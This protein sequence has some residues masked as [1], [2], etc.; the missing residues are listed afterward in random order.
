[1]E[2]RI[3]N[4]LALIGLVTIFPM[5]A[6]SKAVHYGK[7]TAKV[8][9]HIGEIGCSGFFAYFLISNLHNWYKDGYE[10]AFWDKDAIA[11]IRR[12]IVFPILSMI[13]VGAT[14]LIGHG[15]SGLNKELE[16]TDRIKHLYEKKIASLHEQIS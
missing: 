2:N 16:I 14:S 8:A 12:L 1:M 4:I 7:K 5:H 15:L 3:L 10:V 13:G 9:W 6:E 11:P